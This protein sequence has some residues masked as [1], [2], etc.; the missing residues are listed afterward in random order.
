[1]K[2]EIDLARQSHVQDQGSHKAGRNSDG[3]GDDLARQLQVKDQD[4]HKAVRR[5][6]R[7]VDGKGDVPAS[8][9]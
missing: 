3:E 2:K 4:S 9:S 6:G 1:M 7:N 8:K 5:S